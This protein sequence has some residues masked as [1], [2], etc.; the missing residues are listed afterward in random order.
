MLAG[1]GFIKTSTEQDLPAATLPVTPRHARAVP[2][3]GPSPVDG[4]CQA[5]GRHPD[6]QGRPE[7][8]LVAVNEVAGEDW[9]DSRWFR[10][11]HPASP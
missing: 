7:V 3:G 11:G 6:Q 2:T 1:G 10:L 4:R 8:F 9:L 5:R